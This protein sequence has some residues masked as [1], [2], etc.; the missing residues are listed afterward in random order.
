MVQLF[1]FLFVGI[2]GFVSSAFRGFVLTKLWAWFVAPLFGLP[3]LGIIQA[4]GLGMAAS[5]MLGLDSV[6]RHEAAKDA[7]VN[8]KLLFLGIQGLVPSL[9]ALAM[10]W[11]LVHFI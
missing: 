3:Q 10:G 1:A 9:M 6:K 11:A 8:Q 5:M 7:S 4:I 2:F